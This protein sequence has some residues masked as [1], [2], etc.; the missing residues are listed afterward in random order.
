ML[1][2]APT[3]VMQR[4]FGRA[5]ATFAFAQG[6]SA[7]ADLAQSGSAKAMLPRVFTPVPEVVFLNTS[8]GLTGGDSLGY[9]IGLGAG[10]RVLAT[11]QTAERAYASTGLAAQVNVTANLGMGAHLDWLPQETILFE[12]AHVQRRTQ[13]DLAA[14]ASALVVESLVLG[15]HA[16]GEVPRRARLTDTRI[17][18]REGRPFWAETLRIDGTVLASADSPAILGG[19]RALAVIAYVAQNAQDA[20]A[21]L[22]GLPVQDG[23]RVAVS[24]WHGR[25][26]IR[27][28][29]TDSWPLRAQIIRII[30]ALRAAPMPRVWQC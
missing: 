9:H 30:T 5:M 3:P 23:A 26:I 10:A 11:T 29:A 16:M 7:L 13:I 15:R 19:A 12:D 8:G 28:T 25:C 22:R 2:L 21:A 27:I 1:D 17:L 20:A 24:G 18:R 14:R 6:R 4:S